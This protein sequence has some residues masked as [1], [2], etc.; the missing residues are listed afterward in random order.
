MSNYNTPGDIPDLIL[1]QCQGIIDEVPMSE[2][3]EHY[4]RIRSD[5]YDYMAKRFEEADSMY[6]DD[7]VDGAQM[8]HDNPIEYFKWKEAPGEIASDVIHVEDSGKHPVFKFE[9]ND[10]VEDSDFDEHY[11]YLSVHPENR[12]T[13][14]IG[15][16]HTSFPEVNI[17]GFSI[18]SDKNKIYFES[19][20]RSSI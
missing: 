6:I 7:K 4:R 18:D 14:K 5:E 8:R 20:D 2:H 12:V 10:F 17:N 9:D 1:D 11:V 16:G 15:G 3:V 13:G 19:V